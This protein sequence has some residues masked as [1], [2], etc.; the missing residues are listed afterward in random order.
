MKL[1]V[2]MRFVFA[3]MLL[4]LCGCVT[5]VL[6]HG[7]PNFATV[8]PGVYRGGQP[9]EAGWK[10]LKS[11]GVS[12]DVKLNTWDEASDLG[13]FAAGMFVQ[14]DGIIDFWEQTLGRP[15]GYAVDSAVQSLI[16]KGNHPGIFIHCEHGQDRTGLVVAIYRVRV[17][18]WSKADAEK[19]MLARGFHKDLRGLWD[20]WEDYQLR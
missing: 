5:A 10:Y 3:V 15:N 14:D 2:L 13:A 6:T 11:I 1:I 19:E 20:F 12:Y 18:G 8:E 9:T 4:Q 7:V 16:N 17:C